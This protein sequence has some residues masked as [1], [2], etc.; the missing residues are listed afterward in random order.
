MS[1]FTKRP[2]ALMV[3]LCNVDLSTLSVF[4]RMEGKNPNVLAQTNLHVMQSRYI[5]IAH[6]PHTFVQ[7]T[8]RW[9]RV[10]FVV[11]SVFWFI[12]IIICFHFQS[13]RI[14]CAFDVNDAGNCNCN[15]IKWNEN[16]FFLSLS[17][18][19]ITIC[20]LL[21]TIYMELFCDLASLSPLFVLISAQNFTCTA[22]SNVLPPS[23]CSN[24]ISHLFSDFEP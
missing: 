22:V 11:V 18:W 2:C 17:F 10:V 14:S 13:D 3:F 20:T 24:A 9:F 23:N 8:F 6:K 4:Q 19:A 15:T 21:L 12:I 16:L 7:F 1:F 5:V